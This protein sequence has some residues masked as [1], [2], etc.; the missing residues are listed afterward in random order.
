MSPDRY[1]K[2]DHN[3]TKR[4]QREKSQKNNGGACSNDGKKSGHDHSLRF[5]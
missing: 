1:R 3:P 2:E 4:C 5:L